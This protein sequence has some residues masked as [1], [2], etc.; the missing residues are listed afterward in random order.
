MRLL[1]TRSQEK[2]SFSATDVHALLS[3]VDVIRLRSWTSVGACTGRNA[4]SRW[5]RLVGLS[6]R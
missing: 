3:R 2:Q 6:A 1:A 4:A 5:R